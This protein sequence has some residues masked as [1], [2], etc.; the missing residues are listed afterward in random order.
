VSYG[1][2]WAPG[3]D[4]ET[5]VFAILLVAGVGFVEELV[6]RGFLLRALRAE[7][8]LTWAIVVSGVTFG[9]GHV[10][11]LLRGYSLPGQVV[12]IVLAILVG[13]ALA[14]GVVLTGSILPGAVF[15]A[16][17][18]LSGTLT[19]DAV[20]GETVVAGIIVAV[21]IPYIFFLRRRLAAVGPAPDPP[22][23]SV[24]SR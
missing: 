15:H 14:Y 17:F 21:M 12:Q 9:V 16:L 11:N 7:G 22:V 19:S 10:V 13:I 23:A 1:K 5:V 2:G 6:F 18:N 20:W 8:R 3:L 24:G 4:T